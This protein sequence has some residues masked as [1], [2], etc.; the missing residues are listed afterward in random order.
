MTRGA[1]YPTLIFCGFPEPPRLLRAKRISGECITGR[2]VTAAA[3]PPGYLRRRFPLHTH[4]LAIAGMFVSIQLFLGLAAGAVWLGRW[5][6]PFGL[7]FLL[8]FLEMRIVDDIDDHDGTTAPSRS[9]LIAGLSVTVFVTVVLTAAR[10]AALAATLAATTVI[11][12]APLVTGRLR[13]PRPVVLVVY[14]FAPML[15]IFFGYAAWRGQGGRPLT[16]PAAAGV[17]GLFWIAYEVW[18]W[19]REIDRGPG[20]PHGL[21]Q[22]VLRAGVIAMLV[23]AAGCVIVVRVFSDLPAAPTVYGVLLPLAVAGWLAARWRTAESSIGWRGL[24][25]PLA[26]ELGVILDA[27][28]APR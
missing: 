4:A 28:A 1:A 16:V 20:R 10:P 14:E 13:P 11:V 8:L 9:R 25:F 7:A 27:L 2:A 17:T 26:L 6:L 22:P 18:K 15:V 12:A 23:A 19:S 3:H 24:V 21:G 5:A